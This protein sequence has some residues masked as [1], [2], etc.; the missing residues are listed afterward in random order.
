MTLKV[1][2]NYMRQSGFNDKSKPA[3]TDKGGR[4]GKAAHDMA[5]KEEVAS[6]T[7]EHLEIS[8]PNVTRVT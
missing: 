7:C 8:K 6:V 5:K 4:E 1:S 3:R 2:N